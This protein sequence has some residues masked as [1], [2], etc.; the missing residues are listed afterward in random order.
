M[1]R[2]PR[3]VGF[4]LQIS[5]SIVIL[6]GQSLASCF[7]SISLCLLDITTAL[8][9]LTVL[10]PNGSDS[11]E[12]FLGWDGDSYVADYGGGGVGG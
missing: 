12:V 7:T 3:M 2:F 8:G 11:L 5:G 9:L 10:E 6:D 4:P 1:I